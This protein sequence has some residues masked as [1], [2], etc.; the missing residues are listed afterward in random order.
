[1]WERLTELWARIG[2]RRGGTSAAPDL[3]AERA[4]DADIEFRS[5]S[6][7]QAAALGADTGLLCPVTRLPLQKG[8]FLYLCRDCNTAYSA[9]GWDFL[10][11]TDRGRCCHC[12]HTDSVVPLREG[13]IPQ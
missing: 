3:A 13:E 8:S 2:F 5:L 9:E 1:M 7:A 4:D 6:P 12:R 10:R 11:K